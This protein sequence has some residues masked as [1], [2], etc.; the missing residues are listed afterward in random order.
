ME[1]E[2]LC[3]HSSARAAPRAR[4]RIR[5][6]LTTEELAKMPLSSSS[7]SSTKSIRR[8]ASE[9]ERS[10]SITVGRAFSALLRDA[11]AAAHGVCFQYKFYFYSSTALDLVHLF[12]NIAPLVRTSLADDSNPAATKVCDALLSSP[13][14]SSAGVRV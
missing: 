3:A 4:S 2:K 11:R 12:C 7:T 6:T 5:S 13:K 14:G 8:A 1:S 10:D 9:L